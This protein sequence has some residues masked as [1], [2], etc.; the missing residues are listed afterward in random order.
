MKNKSRNIILLILS[1]FIFSGLVYAGNIIS[2]NANA[3]YQ[4]DNVTLNNTG[5][6]Y[7]TSSDTKKLTKTA[8]VVVCR[9]TSLL[10]DLIKSFTCDVVC[11]STNTEC[12]TAIN[13][14][15][16]NN[17]YLFLSRGNYPIGSPINVYN[18]WKL[19]GAGDG[20]V[21]LNKKAGYTG[22]NADIIRLNEVIP[23]Y[24]NVEISG[25]SL[26]GSLDD[27]V[28]TGVGININTVNN[29]NIHDISIYSTSGYG[30]SLGCQGA[31]NIYKNN[32]QV[33]N[34]KI[35]Q[36]RSNKDAFGGGC[37]QD[38][39]IHDIYIERNGAIGNGS[40]I[41]LTN[42]DGCVFSNLRFKGIGVINNAVW[43]FSSDFNATNEVVTNLN[44][45][46]VWYGIFYGSGSGN[47]NINNV[48][49]NRTAENGL[50]NGIFLSGD[51]SAVHDIDFS[52]IHII[53]A[54]GSQYSFIL[55][56]TS[57]INIDGLTIKGISGYGV[58][59]QTS[60]INNSLKNYI[61]DVPSFPIVIGNSWQTSGSST[62]IQGYDYP[63]YTQV[64]NN[65]NFDPTLSVFNRQTIYNSSSACRS[66]GTAWKCWNM[67]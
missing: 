28:A 57:N 18:N 29:L 25:V 59:F 48:L 8:D 27:S 36:P 40:F 56:N 49:I 30:M 41:D 64:I 55:K 15:S 31:T 45:Q 50:S 17:T 10:D 33:Y 67:V 20:L 54:N 14:K 37:L 1:I 19:Q 22:G 9:G 44:M 2:N 23:F 24:N 58:E 47:I 12:S 61:I 13:S 35:I 51:N 11:K 3:Y 5:V 42:R 7:S 26:N 39:D 66:N 4:A 16:S 52:N 60:S 38:C 53:N 63:Y 32:T 62:Y 46:N 34:V 6:Y 21:W 43:G 65:T